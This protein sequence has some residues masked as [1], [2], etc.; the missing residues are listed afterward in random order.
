MTGLLRATQK[1]IALVVGCIAA[2][3]AAF[4]F[5]PLLALGRFGSEF[6]ELA[7]L[8]AVLIVLTLAAFLEERLPASD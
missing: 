6:P 1:R 2:A 7:R 3:T 4:W 5:G 8:G